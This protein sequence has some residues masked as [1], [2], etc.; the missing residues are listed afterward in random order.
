MND[1][2]RYR[3]TV[4]EDPEPQRPWGDALVPVMRI[5]D[6]GRPMAQYVS[7]FVPDEITVGMVNEAFER[8]DNPAMVERWLRIF[9]GVTKVEWIIIDRKNVYMVFD[10]PQW[11]DSLDITPEGIA[12]EDLGYDWRAWFNGEVYGIITEK[13]N[14][15]GDWREVESV[16]GVYGHEYAIGEAKRM[17]A[18]TVEAARG[19]PD[20]TSVVFSYQVFYRVEVPCGTFDAG[21]VLDDKDDELYRTLLSMM[22]NGG[23]V[24][25]DS[26]IDIVST[27]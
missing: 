27:E 21:D 17:E 19:E 3:V 8:L 11:R 1:E 18:Q 13:R 4:V 22:D 26:R 15:A 5:G 2:P 12:D 7:D 14:A 25:V 9:H 23:A 24:R 16:Y 20:D 6:I 10:A